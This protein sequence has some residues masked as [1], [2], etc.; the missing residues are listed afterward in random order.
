MD[1]L[2]LKDVTEEDLEWLHDHIPDGI[3]N[4][5]LHDKWMAGYALIDIADSAYTTLVQLRFSR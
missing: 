4:L 3:W 2:T 1:T 5:R